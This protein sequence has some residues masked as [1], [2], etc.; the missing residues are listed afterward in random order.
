MTEQKLLT[1]ES[2]R[3]FINASHEIIAWSDVSWSDLF[4]AL[5]ESE[6]IWRKWLFDGFLTPFS[7]HA[8]DPLSS[9]KQSIDDDNDDP[10]F[11]IGASY[12]N[13]LKYRFVMR[14]GLYFDWFNANGLV[15]LNGQGKRRVKF[16][17]GFD[18][19][20][21][22]RSLSPSETKSMWRS[23]L[24]DE[25]TRV[26]TS[27]SH[28][29]S[30]LRYHVDSLRELF[31]N[32]M[33][34]EAPLD[35]LNRIFI[36]NVT[37]EGKE[38][39]KGTLAYKREIRLSIMRFIVFMANKGQISLPAKTLAENVSG[40]SFVYT[41]FI[42]RYA[43][44][45]LAG[46]RRFEIEA[47][48]THLNVEY[49]G[50]RQLRLSDIF[51][52]FCASNYGTSDEFAPELLALAQ[53][54]TR[55]HRNH[56]RPYFNGIKDFHRI[57][58]DEYIKWDSVLRGRNSRVVSEGPFSLFS[59]SPHVA[60]NA[61]PDHVKRYKKRTEQNFPDGI[62]TNIK[63]WSEALERLIRKMPRKDWRSAFESAKHWLFYL[64]TL[65]PE[66][67][68]K[69]FA[70]VE[71]DTHIKNDSNVDTFFGY[72]ERNG[73]SAG[74]RLR[75]LY[76]IMQIWQKE[77]P[78][79][80]HLP[81]V[82]S[83]D[84]KNRTKPFRTKRRAIPSLIIETL[85]EE[86]AR[87]CASGIPYAH[88]SKW[89]EDR[90]A[91]GSQMRFEGEPAD[92]KI[93]SVPAAIDC[94]LNLGMRSSSARWLDSGEGDEFIIDYD[95]VKEIPNT[96][97]NAEAGTQAGFLQ[98]MQVTPTEW[99]P[100]FLMLRN[101]T[102]PVH[103][104]PYAPK[105]LVARL[106]FIKQQQLVFN[107]TQFPTHAV[108]DDKT[109]NLE[110]VPLVYPLFRDPTAA[111]GKAVSYAKLVRWWEE[112]LRIC[113]P[114][115]NEKRKLALGD[116]CEYYHFF[117][118]N[119]KPIWD[120]HS[121]RVT[122]VT[123]LLEMGVSPTIVQH[124][125]G[126]KS[127]AMTLHYHAVDARKVG[128]ALTEALEARRIAAAEA[129]GNAKSVE[130]LE[131]VI[132]DV[133]GG[134]ANG[135]SGK[136]FRESAEY[137]MANGKNL[138]SGSA[139]F[140]V[141]SHGICPGGDCSQGGEKRGNFHTPVHRDMAC[142]RCRFRITGPAFLAGLELN[143]NILMNEIAESSRREEKLNAELLELSREGKPTAILESRVTQEQKYRDEVWADW[144]AE[145][146]TIR[147]CLD[148]DSSPEENNLP[149]LPNDVS[150]SLS[151]KSRLPM[152]QDIIGKSKL[153]SGSSLDLPP[154]LIEA[155][156][157][158]LWDI[159]S[160]SGDVASYL[161]SLDKENRDAA[162]HEFGDLICSYA[163]DLGEEPE[164]LIQ[165]QSKLNRLKHLWT[166]RE[167]DGARNDEE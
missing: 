105:D 153:I 15:P 53:A 118:A 38:I 162:L 79:V 77:N 112:L 8:N 103:E 142:S 117:D 129:I 166:R 160:K 119:N 97:P 74:S 54:A 126:H 22:L 106:E 113:E 154:G 61:L 45:R 16:Q 76:Q 67:R 91:G 133:M 163:D 11:L 57:S 146:R 62:D 19:D 35:F 6:Q 141:F 68:P 161:I 81:I 64:C 33:S 167:E 83:L 10:T 31:Q 86:N 12:Q 95:S 87:E 165:D 145:Y 122:V 128:A 80:I 92:V 132:D 102:A 120:I 4:N 51:L 40:L 44:R 136:G 18:A 39:R 29:E 159:A 5:N 148:M 63:N 99:V 25:D 100:S 66:H 55:G 43:I 104:I 34:K 20:E 158:M 124:L 89:V 46:H 147:E 90:G 125:V 101:K 2:E 164:N 24:F 138:K 111:E 123:A 88:Y 75:D 14:R 23:I 56:I 72:F 28:F 17:Q 85:I 58:H 82:S 47:G 32:S 59:L 156:N 143:A 30:S 115:V 150:I 94:I 49:A 70:E 98:R 139:A 7:K 21:A 42:K 137:A 1:T 130:E 9:F 52:L 134:M 110:D 41:G 135:I 155:R 3:Y 71:R 60:K 109:A 78:D 96:H 48:M 27:C 149:A 37:G 140:S 50:A 107:P 73:I 131:E 108:D 127:P 157:D 121:I 65:P 36:E 69:S 93:P 26:S 152:L 114:I 151:E 144:A 13:K 84:W 116:D